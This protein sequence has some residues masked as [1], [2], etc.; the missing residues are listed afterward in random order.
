MAAGT[1]RGVIND[2]SCR[3][4]GSLVLLLCRSPTEWGEDVLGVGGRRTMKWARTLSGRGPETMQ[5]EDSSGERIGEVSG[6]NIS[7]V[8]SPADSVRCSE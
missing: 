2:G 8:I 7:A 3:I 4:A 1:E 5:G 6:L